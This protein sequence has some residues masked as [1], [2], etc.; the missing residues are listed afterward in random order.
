MMAM[1][2]VA[3]RANI[4]QAPCEQ[5]LVYMSFEDARLY[6]TSAL[7]EP[8]KARAVV[9]QVRANPNLF[10]RF[11]YREQTILKGIYGDVRSWN[12]Q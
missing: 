10:T 2:S 4:Y 11:D 9:A 7:G 3:N 12:S 6:M 5:S 1:T 8:A